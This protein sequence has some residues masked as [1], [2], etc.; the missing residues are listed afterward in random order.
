MASAV[1]S[2]LES[3]YFIA[4]THTN[5]SGLLA[6][7]SLCDDTSQARI[8]FISAGSALSILG[9]IFNAVLLYIFLGRTQ[10]S[11]PFQTFLAFLDFMLCA[12]YIHCFG[13]LAFS[14]E[15]RIPFLYDFIMDSNVISLVMS[16]IVQLSIPYTLIANS[17]EKLAMILGYDCESKFSLRVRILIILLLLLTT[18]LLRINGMFLL[19]IHEDPDCPFF[20][21]KWLSNYPEEQEKWSYFESTLTST[22]ARNHAAQEIREQQHK[23]KCAV[24][25]TVVIISAYLA[26]NFINFFLYSLETFKRSWIVEENGGF[27]S[28]YVILSD[29]GSSL[30]VFS[31]S[32]R[33][34]IYY[35]Y[36]SEIKELIRDMA[37][38]RYV[39]EQV[40]GT[41]R[42]TL[43]KLDRVDV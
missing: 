17:A 20:H 16:R 21:R 18:T 30:F 14:V 33:V 28:F 35:K 1:E 24:K 40:N 10:K 12:L 36:N 8:A 37:I 4:E 43:L 2:Y 29:L 7:D 42:D 5:T 41:K 19:F 38:V 34:F 3:D 22:S 32:I 27:A 6:N 23:I 13:L 39:I 11:Y 26:C 25:T 31:S 15:Y 9:C